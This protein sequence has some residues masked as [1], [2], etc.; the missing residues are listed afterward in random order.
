MQKQFPQL[1]T[2]VMVIVV[3]LVNQGSSRSGRG[4]LGLLLAR[5]LRHGR[6]RVRGALRG[7][8]NGFVN[9]FEK[10]QNVQ[11]FLNR[12]KICG[13]DLNLELGY[14]FCIFSKIN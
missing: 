13:L 1:H 4:N 9:F 7:H 5:T 10:K 2:F 3:V 12:F 8:E 11:I 6:F 14:I